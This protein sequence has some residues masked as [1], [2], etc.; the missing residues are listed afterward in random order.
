MENELTIF[1]DKTGELNCIKCNF[2][3]FESIEMVQHIQKHKRILVGNDS[4]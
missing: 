2:K 1:N 3:T 4:K